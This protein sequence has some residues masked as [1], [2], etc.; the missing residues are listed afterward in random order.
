MLQAHLTVVW[1]LQGLAWRRRRRC[2]A[3]IHGFH[4]ARLTGDFGCVDRRALRRAALSGQAQSRRR[5]QGEEAAEAQRLQTGIEKY[6]AAVADIPSLQSYFDGRGIAVEHPPPALRLGREGNWETMIAPVHR[7]GDGFPRTGCHVTKLVRD[8]SGSLRRLNDKKYGK[9]AWGLVSGGIVPLRQGISLHSWEEVHQA[10]GREPLLIGEGIENVESAWPAFRGARSCTH[11][12]VTYLASLALPRVFDPVLMVLDHDGENASVRKSREAFLE[13]MIGEG[14][15]IKLIAPPR[16]QHDMNDHLRSLLAEGFKP[17]F[18]GPLAC[19][20]YRAVLRE[21]VAATRGDPAACY[22][23][24]V[25]GETWGEGTEPDTLLLHPALPVLECDGVTLPAA[26]LP[27]LD[28]TGRRAGAMV[29]WLAQR[30]GQWRPAPLLLP[31]RLIGHAPGV[32]LISRS[33]PVRRDAAVVLGLEEALVYG[34]V[35]AKVRTVLCVLDVS[36]LAECAPC[37]PGEV[38]AV[39]IYIDNWDASLCGDFMLKIAKARLAQCGIKA[40]SARA[41]A[42][43]SIGK[44]IRG[45]A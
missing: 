32:A 7:F 4:R 31:T 2:G 41:G 28:D 19:L 10:E 35:V 34:A 11:L 39:E 45:I 16:D 33:R 44:L 5:R 3:A 38:E 17:A 36:H 8:D 15:R 9:I 43:G 40:V 13:R 12:S 24:A 29:A 25:T 6:E 26:V 1:R 21:T 42:H 18:K 23:E 20:D 14:R 37:V 30:G 22:W 27:L